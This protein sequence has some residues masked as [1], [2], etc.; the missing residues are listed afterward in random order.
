MLYIHKSKETHLLRQTHNTYQQTDKKD[1]MTTCFIYIYMYK[2]KTY[3]CIHI[4]KHYTRH[5]TS[6]TCSLSHIHVHTHSHSHSDIQNQTIIHSKYII[7]KYPVASSSYH[8]FFAFNL[9]VLQ[10]CPIDFIH[11]FQLPSNS[12]NVHLL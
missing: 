1:Y 9:N 11:C 3:L 5:S 4:Y 6:H 12:A 10:A 2:I 8:F 7:I